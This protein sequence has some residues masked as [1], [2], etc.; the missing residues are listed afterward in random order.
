MGFGAIFSMLEGSVTV[1]VP[2]ACNRISNAPTTYGVCAAQA[3]RCIMMGRQPGLRDDGM[4]GRALADL[5]VAP[6][7]VVVHQLQAE[8]L[9]VREVHQELEVRVPARRRAVPC[10]GR[11]FALLVPHRQPAAKS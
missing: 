2:E 8:L 6:D 1:I 9:V 5:G 4:G 7:S 3:A 10:D 11:L